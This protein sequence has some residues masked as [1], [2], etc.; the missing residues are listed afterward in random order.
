[1][2]KMYVEYKNELGERRYQPMMENG[3]RQWDDETYEG[4][5]RETAPKSFWDRPL[6]PRLYRSARRARRVAEL[7][8]T[9]RW[10]DGA[11]R[12]REVEQ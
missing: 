10:L 1:M 6:E 2:Q 11:S 4:A 9:K 7:E 12:F 8:Q 5:W 3:L